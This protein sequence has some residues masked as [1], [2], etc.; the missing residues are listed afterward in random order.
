MGMGWDGIGQ[1]LFLA[2]HIPNFFSLCH[3]QWPLLVTK[4]L[5][6]ICIVSLTT[7]WLAQLRERQSA[8]QEV[9][10]SNSSRTNTKSKGI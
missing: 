9:T 6:C 8:E 10:D 1:L 3:D 7:T 5:N 2:Y 4:C